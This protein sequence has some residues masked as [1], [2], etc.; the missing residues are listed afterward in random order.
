MKEPMTL[1]MISKSEYFDGFFSVDFS[2]FSHFCLII[3]TM[4]VFYANFPS[5][6]PRVYLIPPYFYYII[7]NSFANPIFFKFQ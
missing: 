4:M 7:Q 5:F 1:K 2:V 3:L 6:G